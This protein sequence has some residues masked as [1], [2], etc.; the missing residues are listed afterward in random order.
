MLKASTLKDLVHELGTPSSFKDDHGKAIHVTKW[1]REITEA[2]RE[3]LKSLCSD[4]EK[5]GMFEPVGDNT[6]YADC[7]LMWCG[8]H[9]TE[10]ERISVTLFRYEM[11]MSCIDKYSYE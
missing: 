6:S 1:S 7:C 2:E 8:K 4:I 9:E 10:Y 11:I 3:C 5:S